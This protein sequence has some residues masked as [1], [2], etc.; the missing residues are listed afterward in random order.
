MNTSE[1]T[2]FLLQAG[3]IWSSIKTSD[4]AIQVWSRALSDVPLEAAEQALDAY[5]RGV[6]DDY[7]PKPADIRRMISNAMLKLPTPDDAWRM[8]IAE[9]NRVGPG[10]TVFHDG[11]RYKLE[12]TF[13]V[14]EVALTCESIGWRR[15]C[16]EREDK[17]LRKS[18]DEAY[19]R[20]CDMTRSKSLLSD[21]FDVHE[22]REGLARTVREVAVGEPKRLFELGAPAAYAAAVDGSGPLGKVLPSGG[23]D[24]PDE[25]LEPG[26][27]TPVNP[28]YRDR[29]NHGLVSLAARVR[30]NADG[31]APFGG[32]PGPGKTA[33]IREVAKRGN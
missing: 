11:Q 33:A 12:P 7:P 17:F 14:V 24:R 5:V 29:L 19:E 4:A 3:E 6:Q 30:M 21:G 31:D 16:N 22:Y 25:Q 1:T 9:V 20:Y 23:P 13:P 15:I 2:K 8:V 28:E 10:Q 18:F 26:D 27:A 32:N